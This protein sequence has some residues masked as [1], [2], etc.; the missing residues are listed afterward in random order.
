VFKDHSFVV[1]DYKTT[2]NVRVSPD[3]TLDFQTLFYELLAYHTWGRP[4]EFEHEFIRREV[5]PGFGTRQV[6]LKKDG[7]AA[8]NNA[9]TDVDDYLSRV[10]HTRSVAELEAF[11]KELREILLGIENSKARGY[12]LRSPDK[13]NC[14]RCPYYRTCYSDLVGQKMIDETRFYDTI[15]PPSPVS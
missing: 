13:Q 12:F 2:S 1:R 11:E 6:R 15:R 7:T 3:F 8:K 5:P 10:R 9:S 14:P 4:V